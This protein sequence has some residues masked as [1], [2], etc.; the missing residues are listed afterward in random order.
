MLGQLLTQMLVVE[1]F[2]RPKV[3]FRYTHSAR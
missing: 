1:E 2:V 3:L